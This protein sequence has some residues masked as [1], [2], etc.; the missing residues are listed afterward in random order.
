MVYLLFD[1]MYSIGQNT[2]DQ[3][4]HTIYNPQHSQ[5]KLESESRARGQ[6]LGGEVRRRGGYLKQ[7]IKP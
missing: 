3:Y 1:V 7:S 6:L 5:A 4:I 2:N